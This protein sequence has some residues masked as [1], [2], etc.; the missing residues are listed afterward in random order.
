MKEVIKIRVE[1]SDI[2]N[3]KNPIEQVNE[4]KSWFFGKLNKIAK[5]LARFIKKKDR[6]QINKIT[7]ERK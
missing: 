3:K 2:E 7:N 1:I 5:P 6:P 4:P